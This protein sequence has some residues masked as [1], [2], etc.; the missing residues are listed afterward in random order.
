MNTPSRLTRTLAAL[1]RAAMVPPLAAT[2]SLGQTPAV[3]AVTLAKYDRN[4]NGRLDPDELAAMEAAPR[5][6]IPAAKASPDETIVLSPFEVVSQDRGY[7]ASS[8]MSGT[9]L[10]SKVE[11][12][13]SAI[14]VVTKEQMSDFAMLDI[15]DVFLYE[16]GTEGTGTY[17]DFSVDRNG[18]PVDNTSV[19][20]NGANRVR[21]VGPA[22]I[23]FGNFETSGRVP[24]DPIN[25][26][27][28][29]ISRGPNSTVFGLG[30]AA[31]TVNMQPASANVSRERS[32]L[33]ARVD[34]Y[35]GY[36]TSLDLNRVLKKGVL[37]I[38]GSAVYQ[39]DGFVRKPSGTDTT[40]LNGMI[41]YQPFKYTSLTASHS[42]YHLDGTRTNVTMPRDA[43]TGWK[44]AGSPTW[45]PVTT[46]AKI[47]G[48]AVPG[49]WTAT[50]LPPYFSNA[51]FRTLST[52]F[53]DNGTVGFWSPSRTTSST[54]P[55]VGNQN[56]VLVNTVSE[57]V[58]AS[59]PLFSS[60]PSVD[61]KELY[62]YSSINLAGMN[63][64][65][66]RTLTTHVQ[67]EQIFL[68]TP[69]NL[70]A[71]QAGYYREASTR[72]FRT[73]LGTPGSSGATGYL[74]VD[75]NE[76]MI[77][78]SPNPYF[79]RPFI[80]IYNV[81]AH[82]DNPNKRETA[83]LQLAYRLDL[84]KEKN[85]FRWLGMHQVSAYGEYKDSRSR[86]TNYRDTINSEHAWYPRPTEVREGTAFNPP[87]VARVYYRYYVG[88]ASGQNVDYAPRD[89]APG[90][91]PFR[92]GNGATGQFVTEQADLGAGYWF[93]SSSGWSRSLL[94]TNGAVLQSHLLK[95]RVVTTFGVRK[96]RTFNRGDADPRFTFG[97]D[98]IELID[99]SMYAFDDNGW[100][101][102]QG[103]T[104]T[105][106]VVLKPKPW[107]H[108]HYNQSDSF[109]P[110]NLAVGLFN[111]PL[112][113]PTGEGKDYGFS[114]N[115][116]GGRLIARVN[117]YETT[118][119]NSRNGSMR[120][121]GQRVRSMDFDAPY[122]NVG[123]VV[124]ARGWITNA[125]AAQGVTLSEDEI[126]RRISEFTKLEPAYFIRSEDRNEQNSL[127][128]ETTDVTAK[129]TEFELHY[130]PSNFWTVKLN[131]T[132]TE[133]IDSNLS[134]GV[135]NWVKL[136]QPVWES[137][138]DPE[139]GRPWFTERYDNRTS[140]AQFLQNSVIA[141]LKIA[142]ATEGKSRPQI[143]K[144]RANL[145]TSYRLAG[146]GDNA[147]LKRFTVGGALR[148]EDRGAIGYYG[149]EQLP[150]IITELDPA[151]PVYDK[152]HL[153]GDL[154]LAYRTKVYSDKVAMTLQLN[155][156]N[157]QESGR[158][159][160]IS[161][162]PDGTPNGYRI[163]DPRQFILTATFDL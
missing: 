127:V 17:T 143:R 159:Q 13:A 121:L 82:R 129:G 74:H 38:R 132:R 115:L 135:I 30:N 109:Q 67:L 152:A 93:G 31:G 156:R 45:D 12:L 126:N 19:N 59:Q 10:N 99:G 29:E 95:D 104:K 21:G 28:V 23:S 79:L 33:A 41:R 125:A 118:Q 131:A 105:A 144:Y 97:P 58:R 55:E 101:R 47:N 89:F 34:S 83:R 76:R 16:V 103:T 56:V 147:L 148:W 161:S 6:T 130:N 48:V 11:D 60:D 3:D 24:I 120:T 39:H 57:P 37:A 123:L 108:L 150:A 86:S 100:I 70:L 66:D 88:D 87:N 68:D 124:R 40:R 94:K 52:L 43:V 133:S 96:D 4:G 136:R 92:W 90:T 80:G 85:V 140:A 69:R 145:S 65:E 81:K 15:N 110:A 46:T 114:V 106:G 22:N 157:I 139:I 117:K 78:G 119:F 138:I 102:N 73:L 51:N 84:R 113:N 122:S 155:V 151:R 75:P 44:K 134:P 149:M 112:P 71:L 5:T 1:V 116:F 64:N 91:Y 35:E 54:S 50:S 142:T 63:H 2:L 20:P 62:D 32:T 141:P 111:N 14:T 27:A 61:S 137:I 18:S 36:R 107:F 26:D 153:Y 8:T 160:P 9:R 25:I 98:G 72:N 53:I 158:L 77:D 146:L 7:Y 49:R 163:V 128:A 162:Y 42:Y 154:F